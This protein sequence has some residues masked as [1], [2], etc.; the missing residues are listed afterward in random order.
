VVLCEGT[1]GERISRL[2]H[3]II[4]HLSRPFIVGRN[5]L[6]IGASV[7][8]AVGLRDGGASRN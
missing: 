5:E 4:E 3:D 7:G 2:A 6:H 1:S 8:S